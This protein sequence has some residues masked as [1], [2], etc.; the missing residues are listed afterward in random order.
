MASSGEDRDESG[1][2][3]KVQD[4]RRFNPDGTRRSDSAPDAAAPHPPAA[5]APEPPGATGAGP[6]RPPEAARTPPD[7]RRS[8]RRAAAP[9][10]ETTLANFV[11]LISQM[12]LVHMGAIRDAEGGEAPVSLPIARIFIDGLAVILEKARG[13]L[14]PDEEAMLRGIVYELRMAWV[15]CS[16]GAPPPA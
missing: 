8:D 14:T 12:A 6:T 4:K 7:A 1:E 5:S 2:E 3:F 13:N 16:R 9:P 10:S 11:S 15:E